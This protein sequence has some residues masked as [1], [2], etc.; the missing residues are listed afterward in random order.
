TD[1][2]QHAV[3]AP[4][5]A[6]AATLAGFA[7]RRGYD[8][9]PGA[10]GYGGG[11]YVFSG[12]P[13]L[14]S[15]LVEG[16]DAGSGGGAYVAGEAAVRMEECAFV[17]N[18]GWEGGG[19]HLREA[20]LDIVGGLFQQNDGGSGGGGIQNTIDS[21]LRVSHTVF[22]RNV[23]LESGS[24]PGPAGAGILT[25]GRAATVGTQLLFVDNHAVVG[26]GLCAF[27]QGRVRLSHATFVGNRG[28]FGGALSVWNA[29]EVDLANGV[30]FGNLIGTERPNGRAPAILAASNGDRGGTVRVHFSLIEG[31]IGGAGVDV[32][33]RCA[34]E[35][36]E[37][38]GDGDPAFVA[39]TDPPGMDGVLG[40]GDDGF[41]PGLGSAAAD[42]GTGEDVADLDG[43][44][45]VA[46]AVPDLLDVDG[47][48]DRDEAVPTDVAG[49]PRSVGTAMDIGAYERQP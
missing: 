29:S 7:I 48:G 10:G 46:E 32:C 8:F 39:A 1:N 9:R 6:P 47:D 2:T 37:G 30:L 31:G 16:T 5:A 4:G 13:T 41:R 19:I 21:L 23:S 15:L 35:D 38:N 42:T 11:I 36:V 27:T 44:G 45:D 28:G 25:T 43:D 3:I 26:G 33:A 34:V 20:E 22:D 14:R 12:A 40:T 18:R 17:D 24:S 49:Q